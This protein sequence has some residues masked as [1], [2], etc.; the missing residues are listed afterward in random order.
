MFAFVL[1]GPLA[2]Y[3]GCIYITG[4][5]S[6]TKSKN[7]NK[8]LSFTTLY[9]FEKLTKKLTNLSYTNNSHFLSCSERRIQS[10]AKW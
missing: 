4:A 9:T 2:D 10:E 6:R 1:G 8:E 5:L 3:G 7:E